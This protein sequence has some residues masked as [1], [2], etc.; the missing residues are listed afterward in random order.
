MVFVNKNDCFKEKAKSLFSCDVHVLSLLVWV[1]NTELTTEVLLYCVAATFAGVKK[2]TRRVLF[3][4]C[5]LERAD[6]SSSKRN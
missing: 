1:V 2:A 4:F 5:V 3:A 6:M